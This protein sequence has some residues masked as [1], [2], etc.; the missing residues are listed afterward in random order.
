MS[1]INLKSLTSEERSLQRPISRISRNSGVWLQGKNA[2]KQ[3]FGRE[4]YHRLLAKEKAPPSH[5]TLKDNTIFNVS[6][7]RRENAE[8]NDFDD[9]IDQLSNLNI[10]NTTVEGE[11][12]HSL[13]QGSR[14]SSY[15]FGN[16]KDEDKW[17]LE[18][19]NIE[20]NSSVCLEDF[21]STGN[22]S[23]PFEELYTKVERANAYCMS[24]KISPYEEKLFRLRREKL[25]LEEAYLLKKKCE[26][27]LERTR[28]PN[29][30]WYEMKTKQ[31]NTE[32][33]KHNSL[34]RNEVDLSE[35]TQY[36]VDLYNKS[37]K[38]E[39]FKMNP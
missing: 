26:E 16:T 22:V 6:I 10:N 5:A 19:V 27:E 25:K 29:V 1:G 36:R 34:M 28:L 20:D 8:T 30:K 31:F 18:P 13:V 17:F 11:K 23:E 2:E 14:R 3:K 37:K 4:D 21:D 9:A 12:Y 39:Q 38:Y 15:G 35:L 32:M 7:T 24:A 33:M